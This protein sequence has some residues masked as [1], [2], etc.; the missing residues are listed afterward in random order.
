MI[1][2][3]KIKFV[4]AMLIFGSIGI[5]VKNIQLP[6]PAIVQ[7]RTIIGS[8]FLFCIFIVRKKR[9][10]RQG[11]KKN[12]IPLII[13]G[14]VLGGGWAFLFEAYR[15]TT[16]GIATMAYYCAPIAVFILSPII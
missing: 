2:S 16:V 12:L 4:I 9:I 15:H 13:A 8:I 14:I 6:S 1:K 3:S 7:W 5:F 11:I 10:D